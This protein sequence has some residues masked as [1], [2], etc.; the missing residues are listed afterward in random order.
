MFAPVFHD[1]DEGHHHQQQQQQQRL[2]N[3][4][5]ILA[6]VAMVFKINNIL[7]WL[8]LGVAAFIQY[9]TLEPRY[10]NALLW[11]TGSDTINDN[12]LIIGGQD[13]DFYNNNDHACMS[14]SNLLLLMRSL[15]SL[16][17]IFVLCFLRIM[18][19]PQ[20]SRQHDTVW[21]AILGDM[22]FHIQCR[23]WMGLVIATTC[24]GLGR[25]GREDATSTTMFQ[26][27]FDATETV[28]V[29]GSILLQQLT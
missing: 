9:S 18:I 3:G 14:S 13:D 5:F 7:L 17:A 15:Q 21:E 22:L 8:S 27:P 29:C 24:G 6:R 4:Q 28:L 26:L 23:L 2:P 16:L 12:A 11:G 19:F 25:S 1:D 20:A 10:L